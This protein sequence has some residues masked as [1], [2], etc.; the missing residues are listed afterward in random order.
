[1]ASSERAR[2]RALIFD[3]DPGSEGVAHDI[4]PTPKL[5]SSLTKHHLTEDSPPDID[6]DFSKRK[7][8]NY[9]T[10]LRHYPG[11]FQRF[12]SFIGDDVEAIAPPWQHSLTPSIVYTLVIAC[13][14]E[15]SQLFAIPDATLRHEWLQLLQQAVDIDERGQLRKE[16]LS[17]LKR[18]KF[19]KQPKKAKKVKVHGKPKA[20]I[21]GDE[22]DEEKEQDD[23][24]DEKV[25]E[26]E[27]AIAKTEQER[28][29][30]LWVDL[31][32]KLRELFDT[33]EL[34]NLTPAQ[35]QIRDCSLSVDMYKVNI[36]IVGEIAG[37]WVI[38]LLE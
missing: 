10:E 20:E 38:H 36:S 12:F 9:F 37:V 19:E 5:L 35:Q 29:D 31:S 4:L 1:M 33:E 28:D 8:F 32:E 7:F 34:K 21:E 16:R 27:E 26:A 17:K 2:V 15:T 25:Q 18:K 14:E 23:S 22:D 30:D 11:P 3:N 6:V 24:H 13:C